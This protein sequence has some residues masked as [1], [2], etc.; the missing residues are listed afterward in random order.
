MP[1]FLKFFFFLVPIWAVIG[2]SSCDG[3]RIFSFEMHH[4]YSD[5]VKNWSISSGKLSHSDWPDKGSFDYYA[6]LA[7]RDQILRGR[8]LSDTDTNSPLIFSDGNST[9]R[10]SSLGFLHYTT[11]Q[12]GTPGM[13]FMVALD[14]GSDLF[15]VPCECSKCAP[16]QGSAYASD[17]ELSIYNPEVSSTSK[18]VTC[19]NLLCAHRN[20][21]P[22]TFSNC[23]YSVSYVSAQTSTSGILVEDVL[24][25]TR[26]DKNHE[27]VEAYVTFG[28]G[29]V[30][31]G[32]FLDIAA[33]NGLF[34][35]GMETISVPS[36]LSKDGLTADSFSMCFGND[37]I[38][39]ISFGDKGSPYQQETSF[40]VNPSHPS[41]N[42]TVTQ[43]R[44]GT[45]L[46]DVDITALFDSGTSFTYMVEPTYT[47]LLENFHSQVQD[48]RRQHDSR[49]PF[50]Y[51]YDMS[52]DANASLIPSMSLRMKGG[53]HF[54]VYNPIIVISTQQGELVYCL[55]VVKSMELNI[56]GQNFMT[57]YRVVFD[58]E[59]LV[60]GWEKFNCYD[61][62]D[63]YTFPVK[64]HNRSVPPAVAAGL[65]NNSIADAKK[66][67]RDHSQGSVASLS[68]HRYT[69]L[70][71]HLRCLVIL[72]ILL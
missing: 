29:Q 3:G 23:P 35:L 44:V 15:W 26:E 33:P 17:F 10:I 68:Y 32:S 13:K 37:G 53:S 62:E 66:E 39:R 28:C 8:H 67:T 56:I 58:R 41:Y 24:H 2:P 63:S 40:N 47:R 19:N 72:F 34:G 7:H 27:S 25:L 14:T 70:L 36:I 48:K 61:I 9:V 21:C 43:I 22:G 12:L 54:T 4:R 71:F 69:S 55:A 59:R 46:I 42:I 50:E 30:Q 60:L 6:L 51:C 31:S 11:V 64:P 38:G 57:G 49:I 52:P 20:R 16:T 45:T 18:K 1:C 5:Q 65:G